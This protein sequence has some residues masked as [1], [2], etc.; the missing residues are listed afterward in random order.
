M[1]NET[2]ASQP[3]SIGDDVMRIRDEVDWENGFV[4]LLEGYKHATD[5]GIC[6]RESVQAQIIAY[7]RSPASAAQ[8]SATIQAAPTGMHAAADLIDAKAQKYLDD[9]AGTENDTGAVVFHYG[10]SGRD[11]HS[12]LVELAEEL[13]LAATIQEPVMAAE[14]VGE[15]INGPMTDAQKQEARHLYRNLYHLGPDAMEDVVRFAS[16][17]GYVNGRKDF[18]EP[19]APMVADPAGAES[20]RA[21]F[22]S[23]C[24]RNNFSTNKWP[25]GV[26]LVSETVG[27]WEGWQAALSATVKAVPSEALDK[28]ADRDAVYRKV[29]AMPDEMPCSVGPTICTIPPAG[30]HCT[31]A[32]GHEGPCAAWPVAAPL[33]DKTDNTG[34]K[35]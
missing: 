28:K 21:S 18:A 34:E 24:I 8:A 15:N 33:A 35:A 22:E 12:T 25:D 29:L 20:V 14:P 26:Y 23:W 10:E 19:A 31:R 13:R 9:H 5:H 2:T 16:V 17:C 4:Q 7:V 1:T 11:Y 30:W 6:S 3:K 27:A 32:P